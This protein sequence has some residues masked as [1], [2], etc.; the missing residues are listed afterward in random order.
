MGKRTGPMASVPCRRSTPCPS[1]HPFALATADPSQPPRR[2]ADDP[3]MRPLGGQLVPCGTHLPGVPPP[4]RAAEPH[5][6]GSAPRLCRCVAQ[7]RPGGLAAATRML[8]TSCVTAESDGRC[9][10]RPPP[11]CN[12]RPRDVA[13]H[14]RHSS[15]PC[16]AAHAS[17]PPGASSTPAPSSRCTAPLLPCS[18]RHLLS[19]PGERLLELGDRLLQRQGQRERV[20]DRTQVS[21]AGWWVRVEVGFWGWRAAENAAGVEE[22]A[23]RTQQK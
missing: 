4:A 17:Q 9:S 22:A 11:S 5:P 13:A 7:L 19:G 14:C 10:V 23:L 12:C 6:P 8:Q 1:P 16:A 15:P 18:R 21:L 20:A 2:G 3:W